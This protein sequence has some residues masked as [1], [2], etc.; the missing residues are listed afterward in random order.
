MGRFS[1][2][3]KNPSIKPVRKIELSKH[4]AKKRAIAAVIFLLIGVALLVY[5]F[6]EFINPK[7]G[8]TRIEA[9]KTV[10]DSGE[11][12]FQYY[13]GANGNN[14]KA[15]SNAVTALYNQTAEKAYKLFHEKQEFE[16]IV[17]FYTINQNPNTE[18]EVDEALYNVFLTFKKADSRYIY[19]API[20]SSYNNLFYCDDDIMTADF[21]PLSNEKVKAE[22]K[23]AAEYI[24]DPE[25]IDIRLLGNN[26]IK[27]FVSEEYLKFAQKEGITD[28][29]GLS[30]L[31]NAFETDYLAD[32][33]IKGGFTHGSI[34]SYDGFIRNFDSS[35]TEYSFN[36]FDKQ[37]TKVYLAGVMR[38][39]GARAIVFLR[40]YALNSLDIQHYYQFQNGEIRTAYLDISDGIPK[41]SLENLVSYS[42]KKSCAEIALEIADIFISEKFDKA[43]LHNL[44]DMEVYSIYSSGYVLYYNEKDLMISDL[45]DKDEITY[46]AE[47]TEK[48]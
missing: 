30:W 41:N 27:L 46:K 12:V 29:I 42:A 45:F 14:V 2:N 31:K 32:A 48:R 35:D 34:S 10:N 1:K 5:C 39:K 21:D 25:M 26:K 7:G 6:V 19:I 17:N 16:G 43:K 24:N 36:I 4:N 38:Y 40:N 23:A 20:S 22:Y 44:S 15:E 3:R 33:M 28:F 47:N 8:W 9:S 11:F 37:G 13:L 18:L